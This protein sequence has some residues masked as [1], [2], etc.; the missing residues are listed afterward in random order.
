MYTYI[1]IYI[2]MHIYIHIHVY[3]CIYMYIYI[4]IY[5]HTRTYMQIYIYIYPYAHTHSCTQTHKHLHMYIQTWHAHPSGN[6]CTCMPNF[7]VPACY[8]TYIRTYITIRM[9]ACV[10]RWL[11]HMRIQQLAR[12]ED[13]GHDFHAKTQS[14]KVSRIIRITTM[15][16]MGDCKQRNDGEHGIFSVYWAG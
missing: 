9:D 6:R 8:C 16:S 12:L 13:Y 3:T 5:T 14:A 1:Y 2:H 4:T 15:T 7:H 10:G 11:H